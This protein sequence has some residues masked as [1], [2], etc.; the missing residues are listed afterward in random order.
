MELSTLAL[1]R[2]GDGVALLRMNRPEKLNAM[3]HAFFAELPAALA[4]LDADPQVAVCVLTGS[5]R[6]FTVGGDFSDFEALSGIDAYRAQV[7]SALRAFDS[8][9]RADTI[10]IAAV[11]GLAIAGGT[12]LTLACDFALASER[13]VF[14]FREASVGLMPS[15]GLMRAPEVIGRAWTSWLALTARD[16]DADAAARIGLVQDVVPHERLLEEATQ[17]AREVASHPRLA[18][19]VGKRLI[20]R[21]SADGIVEAIEASAILFSNPEHRQRVADFLGEREQRRADR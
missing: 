12:E 3:N 1:Q 20:N 9:Q 21:R 16:L 14:G 19:S 7:R 2:L 13:A 6:A 4:E 10:V 11:D 15:Y 5:G 8:V 17:L 18:T